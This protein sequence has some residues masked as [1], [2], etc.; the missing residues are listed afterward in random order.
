MKNKNLLA[1]V[2][3]GCFALAMV[4][5]GTS[6]TT[7]DIVNAHPLSQCIF[8]DGDTEGADYV[9]QHIEYAC[10]FDNGVKFLNSSLPVN[11]GINFYHWQKDQRH[12]IKQQARSNC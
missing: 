3:A 6:K 2:I 8:T 5:F 9:L 4:F 11:N 12:Y 10:I 7:A 1:F